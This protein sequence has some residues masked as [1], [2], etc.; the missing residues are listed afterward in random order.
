MRLCS[1]R[2]CNPRVCGLGAGHSIRSTPPCPGCRVLPSAKPREHGGP[3]AGRRR[4]A[5]HARRRAVDRLGHAR[6]EPPA[7]FR[8]SRQ[9]RRRPRRTPMP[10]RCEGG[11][12]YCGLP[13]ISRRAAADERGAEPLRPRQERVVCYRH[14]LRGWGRTSTSR[15][16][17]GGARRAEPDPSGARGAAGSSGGNA[18]SRRRPPARVVA[19]RTRK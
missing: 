7:P 6:H 8:S 4:A 16:R 5:L 19:P 11:G 9:V 2:V 15:Q 1:P 13:A 14:Y 17:T 3:P 18:P 10:A 12:S